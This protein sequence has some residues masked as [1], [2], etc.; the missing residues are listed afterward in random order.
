[1]KSTIQESALR[2]SEQ[3]NWLPKEG[4]I[5]QVSNYEYKVYH[6]GKWQPIDYTE[7]VRDPL[8]NWNEYIDKHFR[9]VKEKDETN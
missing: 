2:Y 1:M 9:D 8:P 6:N 5:L 4:D 7:V 3:S